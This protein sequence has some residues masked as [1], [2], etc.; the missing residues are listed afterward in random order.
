MAD[1][2]FRVRR[3]GLV[4]RG[5]R[6][7]VSRAVRDVVKIAD[8][9]AGMDGMSS[10]DV[11]GAMEVARLRRGLSLAVSRGMSIGQSRAE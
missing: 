7:G 11:A 3:C 9:I 8:A 4:S 5:P 2:Y 1:L 10:V 6:G